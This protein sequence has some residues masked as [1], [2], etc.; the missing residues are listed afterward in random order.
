MDNASDELI[1]AW[2]IDMFDLERYEALSLLAGFWGLY[3]RNVRSG[4]IS[5]DEWDSVVN[6]VSRKWDDQHAAYE[7]KSVTP[8]LHLFVLLRAHLGDLCRV[9]DGRRALAAVQQMIDAEGDAEAGELIEQP[10]LTEA[11]APLE[12]GDEVIVRIGRSRQI[13]TVTAIYSGVELGYEITPYR[14][15]P[16]TV[17][18]RDLARVKA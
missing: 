16:L 15:P 13:G 7:P 4:R 10:Y 14:M 6:E 1:T 3:E 2:L 12:V 17:S 9:K 11:D 5:P 18:L 8:S